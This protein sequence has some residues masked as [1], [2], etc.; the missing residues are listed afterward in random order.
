[1]VDGSRNHLWMKRQEKEKE[2]GVGIEELV[3]VPGY[4]YE[5]VKLEE[6]SRCAEW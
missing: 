6:L 3:E 4:Q 5:V 2:G 1:M